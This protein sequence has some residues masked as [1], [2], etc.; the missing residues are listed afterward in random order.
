M[1]TRIHNSKRFHGERG[2]TLVIFTLSLFLL[3]GMGALGIDLASMYVARSESQQAAD[4]AALA[5]A[6]YFVESGCVTN[7]NCNSIETVATGRATEV[8]SQSIVGGQP[9]TLNGAPTFNLAQAQN[10][11]ITVNVQSSPLR[12]YFLPALASLASVVGATTGPVTPITVGATATAEAYNPSGFTG[13][14][15]YCTGCIRPWL[16]PNCDQ[17]IAAGPNPLCNSATPTPEGYL[18]SPGNYSVANAGCTPAGVVGEQIEIPLPTP[19]SPALV[20]PTTLY[21][22]VDVDS[23]GAGNL[24]DY[25][26]AIT[27]CFTGQ[28]TCGQPTLN[29]LPINAALTASTQTGAQNLLHV[30]ASGLGL[31]QD[32]IDTTVC[33]PQIHAGAANPLVVQGVLAQDSVIA[34]SD[35]IVSAY[36]YDA[37]PGGGPYTGLTYSILPN[38]DSPQV[39]NIVGFAQ[40]FVSQV[41]TAGNVWGNILGVA[42]CGGNSGG[43]CGAGSGSSSSINGP[44][45][46]PVR[47]IS[48]GN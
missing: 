37:P 42:G 39:V 27:T 5:G 30:A 45:L 1:G 36:I 9:V 22:A 34:T 26:T 25:Q 13:G 8:A 33:P 14:P 21:G 41:D 20:P 10:P 40:I 28:T 24:L 31:G 19:T 3:V 43:T 18:L 29:V 7:G 16:I 35:S 32:Y 4:S 46:I 2:A 12:L 11:Q 6:K 23:P 17:T 15:T 48:P 47:L 44:S 38:V